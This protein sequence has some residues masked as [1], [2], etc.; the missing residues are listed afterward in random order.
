MELTVEETGFEEPSWGDVDQGDIVLLS[1][2]ELVMR[3]FHAGDGELC[4]CYLAAGYIVI[5]GRREWPKLKRVYATAKL[6]LS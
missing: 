3:M 2:G 4:L 6:E 5:Y 1:N